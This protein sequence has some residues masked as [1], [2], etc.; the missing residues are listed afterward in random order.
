MAPRARMMLPP[1]AAWMCASEKPCC[2]IQRVMLVKFSVVPE[3]FLGSGQSDETEDFH[4]T[5]ERLSM[6]GAAMDSHRL[7]DLVT[8]GLRGVQRRHWVLEDHGDVVATDLV[9]LVVVER[10]EV[11]AHEL[12]APTDDVSAGWQ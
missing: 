3:A 9:H 7:G 2:T 10:G 1:S 5:V 4:R 11:T 12:D 6:V 8:D